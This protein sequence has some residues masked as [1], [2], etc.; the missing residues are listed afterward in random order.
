MMESKSVDVSKVKVKIFVSVA[1]VGVS[2]YALTLDGCL[3]VYDKERRNTK[4]I[5]TRLE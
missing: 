4:L 1:I 5:N 3:A 2:I